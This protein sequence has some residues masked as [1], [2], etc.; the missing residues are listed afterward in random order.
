MLEDPYFTLEHVVKI[1][2]E[3]MASEN[4]EYLGIKWEIIN[5]LT[6]RHKVIELTSTLPA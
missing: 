6:D 4:K 5:E 2:E 3:T 1:L